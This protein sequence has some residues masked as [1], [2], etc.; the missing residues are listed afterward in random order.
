MFIEEITD[1]L[2]AMVHAM[3]NAHT[4][5]RAE[6]YAIARAI[7]IAIRDGQIPKVK[8]EDDDE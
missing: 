6:A 7:F 1:T 4:G 2:R 5:N 3:S 8:L